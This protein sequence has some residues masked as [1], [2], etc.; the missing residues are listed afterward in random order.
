MSTSPTFV[1]MGS[2]PNDFC[3]NYPL[4][5]TY[6]GLGTFDW[7]V[8]VGPYTKADAMARIWNCEKLTQTT[9][10]DTISSTYGGSVTPPSRI[11]TSVSVYSDPVSGG[12]PSSR[13]SMANALFE[14]GFGN[15]YIPFSGWSVDES[16]GQQWIMQLYP[17]MFPDRVLDHTFTGTI[18]GISVTVYCARYG[19]SGETWPYSDSYNVSLSFWTY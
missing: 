13:C 16:G 2:W 4:P 17:Y 19:H 15:Y 3:G 1:C 14:D 12:G 9:P 18:D 7:A 10:I 6:F 11:C 5:V 8:L